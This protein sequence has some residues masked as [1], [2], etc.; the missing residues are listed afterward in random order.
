M[1]ECLYLLEV[2]TCGVLCVTRDKIDAGWSEGKNKR[3]HSLFAVLMRMNTAGAD[4][5]NYLPLACHTPVGD[6]SAKT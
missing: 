2:G 1:N 3:L 6:G 5:L 4:R